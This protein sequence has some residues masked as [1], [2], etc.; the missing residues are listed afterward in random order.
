MIK[1]RKI[2]G[3]GAKI[4]FRWESLKRTFSLILSVY[5]LMVECSKYD[6]RK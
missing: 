1:A 3:D 4:K 6:K 5:K 2:T